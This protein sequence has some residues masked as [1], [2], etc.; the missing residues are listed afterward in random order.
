MK[1]KKLLVLGGSFQHCKV[2]ECAKKM[3]IK[4]YVADYLEHSPAKEIADVALLL[5]VKATDDIIQNCKSEGIDGVI[6]TSLD[7]CQ[8]PYEYI[9]RNLGL[10]CFGNLNQYKTLTNK[11][12]F[13]E[14]CKA[15]HVD[16]IET[17]GCVEDIQEKDYP[18]LI[19]PSDSRGSRGQTIC[20]NKIEA[21]KGVR[22]AIENSSDKGFVIEKYMG[23][24]QD[25]TAAYLVIDGK[26]VLVRTGDR[27][28]GTIENGLN[29]V[30]IAS[31]SP[32]R[33]NKMYIK[34]VNPA[35]ADMINAL[36][37]K[38]GPVF[39]QGFVDGDTVRFYDPGLRFSGGE[40]E[41]LFKEIFGIDLIEALVEYAINGNISLKLDRTD[42][43]ALDGKRIMQLCP[44]LY[45]GT[46]GRIEGV[47]AIKKHEGVV[48]FFERYEAGEKVP[49]SDDVRRRFAEICILGNNTE[50]MEEIRQ[51]I[52]RTLKITDTEGRNMICH[53]GDKYI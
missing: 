33:Y 29:K 24:K 46:I 11:N 13:K 44:A 51:Y 35:V 26:A 12:L 3:G 48:S 7:P 36:G 1:N 42:Y 15:H 32:S 21:E 30:C 6:N 18:V 4:V 34:N 40:Y 5:D 41:R 49:E 28:T 27:Y 45:S 50:H 19:K 10:P 23:N 38:N 37:I 22:T 25:F 39:F 17:Y 2:V 31:I 20:W 47:E 52:A 53:I 16:I 14:Y 8:I 9:C 43:S